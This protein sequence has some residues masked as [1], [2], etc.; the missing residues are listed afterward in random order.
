MRN[1]TTLGILHIS[2]L[3]ERAERERDTW[4]RRRVLSTAW[5][6]N[7]RQI[8]SRSRIDLVCFTGDIADWG[9]ANEFESATSF[10]DRT[11]GELGLDRSRLFLVPGNHDIDRSVNQEH[12]LRIRANLASY[13]SLQIARWATGRSEGKLGADSLAKVLAR[14]EHYRTWLR[15]IG[16]EELLPGTPH[17]NLGYRISNP[18]F[19]GDAGIVMHVIGLDS[20]WLSADEHDAEKLRLTDEQ[21]ARLCTSEA[22]DQLDGFRLALVHHPLDHLHDAEDARRQ[23]GEHVDLLLRGHRHQPNIAR[24]SDEHQ[25]L[26]ELAA[27]CLYEGERADHYQNACTIIEVSLN[28]R[29]RPVH[30][31]VWFRAWSS[32]GHW[33]DD[34]SQYRGTRS[35]RM[36]VSVAGLAS[37]DDSGWRLPYRLPENHVV[38]TELQRRLL[39]S[40][41]PSSTTVLW[42][43]GGFGKTTLALAACGD[44]QFRRPFPD[45]VFWIT[46]GEDAGVP[47]AQL[48]D[49][50]LRLTGERKLYATAEAMVSDLVAS[51]R[52]RK[53][54]FI[55]DD[56]WHQS[57]LEPFLQGG[58][59][60]ARLITTRDRS[61]APG[62]ATVL[63]VVALA[64]DEGETLLSSGLETKD[65]EGRIRNLANRLGNWPLLLN[66]VNRALNESVDQ[67][68]PAFDALRW[69]ESVLDSRGLTAFDA[70]DATERK[71]AV[72]KTLAVSFALLSDDEFGRYL[73]LAAF[74]Q[75]Y[76]IPVRVVRGLWAETADWSSARSGLYCRRLRRLALLQD[77]HLGQGTLRLHAVL[78]EYLS[79]RL[80]ENLREVHASLLA[81]FCTRRGRTI[82]WADDELYLWDNVA[83][84][85]VGA[86]QQ[87]ELESLL[88]SARFL[89]AKSLR[90]GPIRVEGDFTL[91]SSSLGEAY[92]LETLEKRFIASAHL[93][94]LVDTEADGIALLHSRMPH[95]LEVDAEP[96]QI[97]LKPWVPFPDLDVTGIGSRTIR[98]ASSL[99]CACLDSL[100]GRLYAG[101][102]EGK[103]KRWDIRTGSL[104][105]ELELSRGPVRDLSVS[106]CGQKF[107]SL[108]E[109]GS[110]R[111]HAADDGSTVREWKVRDG[112]KRCVIDP[113]GSFL[114]T[115]GG[116]KRLWKWDMES[117]ASVEHPWTHVRPIG[118]FCVS[119]DGTVVGACFENRSLRVWNA[120]SGRELL[121]LPNLFGVSQL[122]ASLK[123][124]RLLVVQMGLKLIL[125]DMRTTQRL[126]ETQI[127]LFS[128]VS[129]SGDESLLVYGGQ[130]HSVVV[131][132]MKSGDV[133]K[134]VY[135]HASSVSRAML[136]GDNEVVVSTSVDGT[137][138]V[139]AW[140]AADNSPARATVWACEVGW[141][142]KVLAA[143]SEDGSVSFWN[144]AAPQLEPRVINLFEAAASSC[145]PA[146]SLEKGR[147][148]ACSRDGTLVSMSTERD[149]ARFLERLKVLEGETVQEGGAMCCA[150]SPD[151]RLAAFGGR[152]HVE[153]WEIETGKLLFLLEGHTLTLSDCTFV[154]GREVLVSAAWDQTIRAW[155]LVSGRALAVLREHGHGVSSV[156]CSPDGDLLVS[157]SRD[158][159]V[160]LW[161]TAD[162]SPVGTIKT[163]DPNLSDAKLSPD[164]R[165]LA[166]TS[167]TGMLTLWSVPNLRRIAALPVAA[168]LHRCAWRPDGTKLIAA[169]HA[170]LYFV[171]VG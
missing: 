106:T 54:L 85:L 114:F 6:S 126:R 89:A 59:L 64:N 88:L 103:V 93:F 2:D 160:R 87:N 19:A 127:D 109:S 14:Q 164:G 46:L 34:D 121:A 33:Y 65:L 56:V 99:E 97:Q 167:T 17:P 110:V 143:A 107:A 30:Y 50:I 119:S 112:C 149:A 124:G 117:G 133:V 60:C 96:G 16:R 128:G 141:T 71:E 80:G 139:S 118:E 38:R 156:N 37:E 7:L 70:D 15:E 115:F 1:E 44:P 153:V 132:S 86:Y 53:A 134:E 162:W 35:G 137:I 41:R 116:G 75:E 45:G 13:R 11:L 10:I 26:R 144:L 39:A 48:Q 81:H 83:Y 161:A 36:R 90:R 100:S 170:G 73:E 23:L 145:V 58:E 28:E 21:I 24:W 63:E 29:S 111:I 95:L 32:R 51:L 57:K 69:V 150:L 22:G 4:R 166:V 76:D 78:R 40:I 146:H 158:A 74:P 42:G 43:T 130:G 49:L 84:H 120:Q 20:A 62:N 104:D 147:F 125:F 67:G 31:E 154:P 123:S 169:G 136:T 77:L 18:G 165:R 94:G 47:T 52:D 61:L 72:D 138:R 79:E 113:S 25:Q 171:D 131:A 108:D 9:R 5:I 163:E 8:S 142:G 157:T 168:P 3:H 135:A 12:L 92:N 140:T 152:K 155:S 68:Q 91:L 159:T 66:L 98:N 27:G 55:L 101:D 105:Y 148:I 82:G 102:R 129:V 151:D 122:E